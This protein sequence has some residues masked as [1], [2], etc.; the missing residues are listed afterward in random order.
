MT[1]KLPSRGFLTRKLK[2]AV[3]I[4]IL[5]LLIQSYRMPASRGNASSSTD[6]TI[7]ATQLWSFSVAESLIGSPIIVDGYIYVNSRFDDPGGSIYCLNASTGTEVWNYTTY[8]TSGDSPPIN[9][10][11]FSPIVVDSKVYFGVNFGYVFCLDAYTGTKKWNYTTGNYQGNSPIFTPTAAGNIVYVG[12]G[13]NVYALNASNG[14]KIWNY[15][16]EGNADSPLFLT[17]YLYVSSGTS[18]Y[19]LGASTGARIWNYTTENST[20]HRWAWLSASSPVVT[21]GQVFVGSIGPQYSTY[22]YHNVYALNAST[23]EQIW[24]YTIEGNA[25]HLTVADGVVYV[26]ASFATSRNRDNEGN[27]AVYALKPTAVTASL[28]PSTIIVIVSVMVIVI[29]A[30]LFLAYRIRRKGTKSSPRNM[31]PPQP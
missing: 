28:P 2:S 11:P 19:C 15:T 18:V 6:S 10:I 8:K 22:P 26:G 14:T 3:V 5:F 25:G 30:V 1:K 9:G 12:A 21:D 4:L 27:G 7:V 20:A 29:L 23:G 17:P 31:S 13:N 24:N 16:T